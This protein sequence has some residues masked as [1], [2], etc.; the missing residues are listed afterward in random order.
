MLELI[1]KRT[2]LYEGLLL[3]GSISVADFAAT[4]DWAT[5]LV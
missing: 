4:R 5:A 1:E 3:T 2:S